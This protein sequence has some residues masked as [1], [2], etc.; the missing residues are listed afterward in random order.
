[1]LHRRLLRYE[2]HTPNSGGTEKQDVGAGAG[3]GFLISK[4]ASV[5]KAMPV[6]ICHA[7]SIVCPNS[8]KP[9]MSDTSTQIGQSGKRSPA[10]VFIFVTVLL[11][12]LAIGIVIPVLPK[13]VLELT[14]GSITTAAYAAGLFLTLFAGMQFI[15]SPIMGALSDRFGRRPVVLLSNLGLGLDYLLMAFAPALW[16]LF[17]GRAIGG[18]LSASISAAQA[19]IAD[20][21]PPEG[22]AKAFGMLSAAFGLGFVAGPVVGGLL[23]QYDLRLPFFAAAAMSFCNFLYGWLV[24]P[25]SLPM[26][27][28]APFKLRTAHPLTAIKMLSRTPQL[29]RLGVIVFLIQLSHHVFQAVAVLY[30]GYR[31]S[32]SEWDIGL[33]LALVGI[34]S[35]VVQGGLVGPVVKTIGEKSTLSV[36]LFCAALGMWIYG[37]APTGWIFLAGVFAMAPWNL[38]TPAA[39]A[40]M[41]AEVQTEEQGRLQGAS[42]SLMG[43]SGLIAPWSFATAFA[44]GVDPARGWNVPGLPFY[45]SASLMVLALALSL[46]L[47]AK[48]ATPAAARAS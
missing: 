2:P 35:M 17:V 41:T 5:S 40:L 10:F 46:T 27:R 23:G 13:L 15:F 33:V 12:M 21:T 39:N 48:R 37:V 32:W 44:L 14:G 34:T 16:V 29:R 36:G 38:A 19:Y 20:I 11:D 22:R 1:M 30:M 28:R 8:G 45:I 47:A 31:F 9:L 42:A 24:L 6:V 43:L 25:E 4:S 3:H 26:D 7:V 18:V